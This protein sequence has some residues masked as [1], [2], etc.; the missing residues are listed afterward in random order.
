MGK[1]HYFGAAGETNLDP[2]AAVMVCVVGLLMLMLPRRQMIGAYIAAALMIPT[3]QA[4]ILAGLHFTPL[5][6]L[7]TFGWLRIGWARANGQRRLFGAVTGIDKAVLWWAIASVVTFALLW[8]ESAAFVSRLGLAY[9]VLGSYFLLKFLIRN[10]AEVT[11]TIRVLAWVCCALGIVMMY[12]QFTGQNLFS[13]ISILPAVA[14]V[15]NGRVRAQGPFVHPL[16]AGTVGAAL[17]PVFVGWWWSNRQMW[18]SAGMGA[19]GATLMSVTSMSSTP[20]LTLAAGVAGTCCWPMRRQMCWVRRGALAVLVVLHLVMKA[21]VWALIA[22]L[23]V[24]GG[25][26]YQRYE[27][28]NQTIRHFG[29]WWLLGVKSTFEWGWDMWDTVNWY[30]TQCTSGGLITAVLF[31]AIIVC[32]FKQIGRALRRPD[33]ASG[34][35]RLLWGLGT[36]LF[37]NLVAFLGVGYLD[38]SAVAWYALLV[39]ISV[40][41]E[42]R[43]TATSER[44]ETSRQPTGTSAKPLA[45]T[46]DLG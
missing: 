12:E 43:C 1:E 23:D 7:A 42:R 9:S 3:N 2:S 32:G 15:R 4:L 46:I 18:K 34:E 21:P 39:M 31:V 5:R 33:V 13:L 41:T 17:V 10:D 20:L 16:C 28:V 36:A 19:L 44:A 14:Q 38:Q 45:M 24:I 8:Q 30:V 11:T 37:A 40:A 27:L 29:E 26:G 25:S 22:R 6:L 35:P